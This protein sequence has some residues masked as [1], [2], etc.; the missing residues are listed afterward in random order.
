MNSVIKILQ[1]KKYYVDL[2]SFYDGSD[3]CIFDNV[4]CNIKFVP[5]N[6]NRIKELYKKI[7]FY[8]FVICNTIVTVDYAKFCY[9]HG[10]PHMLIIRE[11]KTLNLLK[12]ECD[13]LSEFIHN[14]INN[15]YCVSEYASDVIFGIFGVRVQILHNFIDDRKGNNIDKLF[16]ELQEVNFSIVGSVHY[17]KSFDV[18]IS[19]FLKLDTS[20]LSKWKLNIIGKIYDNE[21]CNKLMDISSEYKNITWCGELTGED[22]WS[23]FENTDIFLVP[24]RDES[25]S[26]VVL[27]AA[28]LGKPCII[29][30]NVGARYIVE[31]EAGF[32]VKTGDSDA[33]CRCLSK[34]IFMNKEKLFEM[35]KRARKN[36]EKTSTEDVYTE[37]IVNIINERMRNISYLSSDIKEELID[38]IAHIKSDITYKNG[39][40]FNYSKK[41]YWINYKI[42]RK[43]A[44]IVPV[45]NGIHHLERLIPPL[46]RHTKYPHKFIFIDDCSN[47]ETHQYIQNKISGRTDCLL[48]RNEK[49]EGFV[50]SVN[51]AVEYAEDLDFVLL[52]SDTE[53]P[54]GW[55]ERLVFP[56]I[57]DKNIASV[58]PFSSCATI[59]SFPFI[60]NYNRNLEILNKLGLEYI[61]KAFLSLPYNA[62]VEVPTGHGFC[63]AISREAWKSV[64]KLNELLYKRGYG[65]EVDWCQRAKAAGWKNVLVPN[66]FVAHYHNGSFS[67]DEKKQSCNRSD[68]IINFLY[69]EYNV[70]VSSF[71]ESDIL[72][73]YI[74]NV[75]IKLAV[76]KKYNPILIYCD[77]NNY[78]NFY[79]NKNKQSHSVI[80]YSRLNRSVHIKFYDIKIYIDHYLDDEIDSIFNSIN[81]VIIV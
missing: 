42:E 64:G 53:V 29:S 25:C 7:R 45:Y 13:V 77:N 33:L 55:L 26:R 12:K 24:S 14:D 60:D 39:Y 78:V 5:K 63:M 79:F 44:V 72:K 76:D 11:A 66:L 40:I 46:F 47:E 43:I 35:G 34:V 3:F 31:N 69:P 70:Q 27:E 57:E 49:N 74:I 16:N 10:I 41:C 52:N 81:N 56:I 50:R 48:I 2:W 32:I 37:K 54:D 51:K 23:A 65:E 18:A 21:Y 30:E 20:I 6:I 4:D 61:D 73:K 1:N 15:I 75:L 38:K 59:F 22:K 62:P 36:Y 17:I 8:D 28:M 58:T 19:S 67:S 9:Q 68:K 71:V 80:I